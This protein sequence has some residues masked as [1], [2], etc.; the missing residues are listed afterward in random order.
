MTRILTLVCLALTVPAS[1]A[2]LFE[3]YGTYIAD[4]SEPALDLVA[5]AAGDLNGDG[6]PDIG[7]GI[8]Y[9][10][11]AILFQDS[12]ARTWAVRRIETEDHDN[13]YGSASCGDVNRDGID[14][15][16]CVIPQCAVRIL[17]GSRSGE[18]TPVPFPALDGQPCYTSLADLRGEDRILDLFG[19]EGQASRS[20]S[21]VIFRG[22]GDGTFGDVPFTVNIAWPGDALAWTYA[23][24]GDIDGDGRADLAI[25]VSDEERS[26]VLALLQ[27]PG[28][29]AEGGSIW[30]DSVAVGIR[31]A[32]LDGDGRG[33]IVVLAQDAPT[34]RPGAPARIR[35]FRSIESGGIEEKDAL[36]MPHSI[37]TAECGDLDR[38]G[39]MD[40]VAASEMGRLHVWRQTKPWTFEIAQVCIGGRYQMALADI[41]CDGNLDAVVAGDGDRGP[42]L[43]RGRGDGTFRAAPAILESSV[44]EPTLVGD[45]DGDG[46]PD[47]LRIERKSETAFQISFLRGDGR[48]GF[49]PGLM[50]MYQFDESVHVWEARL[51]DLDGDRRRDL[52]LV[53]SLADRKKRIMG[54][55]GRGDGSFLPAILYQVNAHDI[56]VQDI[57]GDGRDEVIAF[58]GDRSDTPEGEIRIIVLEERDGAL[59]QVADLAT[60]F[61]PR[62]MTVTDIDGDA[63]LDLAI[64]ARL[65][66]RSGDEGIIVFPGE[67]DGTFGDPLPGPAFPFW[68]GGPLVAADWDGDGTK[69]LVFYAGY[70]PG[71]GDGTFAPFR[72]VDLFPGGVEVALSDLDR[73][74][75]LDVV[76]PWGP[77]MVR[78]GAGA[79]GIAGELAVPGL[80]ASETAVSDLDLDG[81]PDIISIGNVVAVYR[82]RGADPGI[83]FI[84]GDANA[85]GPIEI[86]DMVYVLNWLF[87]G[88][89]EPACTKTADL[90]D[91][92]KLEIGDP[93]LGLNYLFASGPP[94]APPFGACGADPTPDRLGCESYAPCK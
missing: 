45:V 74:G 14:D 86:S 76:Y 50:T 68:G 89:R 13:E 35:L 47:I 24:A 81:A 8:R 4:P 29:F 75:R 67:S 46:V 64:Y 56:E 92:G 30:S 2:G 10:D 16:L 41:D 21:V 73:D 61:G 54:L 63:R 93:I 3:E 1:A 84:R 25:V 82:N 20:P 62:A 43:L 9:K 33:D 26:K 27:I 6:A 52:V 87:A 57:E 19:P 85:D 65:A 39:L 22:K 38:D 36:P 71:R 44:R 53:A 49:A 48:T 23:A 70:L 11:L 77:V 42:L 17:L 5:L 79:A 58:D 40:I 59:E 66:P 55:H 90:D 88:G 28:G 34:P 91:S 15:L 83:R 94:P 7:G 80:Y 37:R 72:E 32:D 31:V 60:S 18:M 12:I 69:D 78:F 51:G